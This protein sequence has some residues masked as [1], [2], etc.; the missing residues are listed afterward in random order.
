MLTPNIAHAFAEDVQLLIDGYTATDAPRL[1]R[2]YT[3]DAQ[4]ITTP[5]DLQP[6]L[7]N[8][9][10]QTHDMQLNVTALNAQAATLGLGSLAD[11]LGTVLTTAHRLMGDL[12]EAAAATTSES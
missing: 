10:R 11:Q 5:Q 1:S 3:R 6:R 7:V 9:H 12:A 2:K 8:N 4:R